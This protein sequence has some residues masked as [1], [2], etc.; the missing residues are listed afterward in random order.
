MTTPA[1]S[2]S[3]SSPLSQ[4]QQQQLGVPGRLLCDNV[5]Y[6]GHVRMAGSA[7]DNK[8][9]ARTAKHI[10]DIH[11]LF[12][13]GRAPRHAPPHAG[14]PLCLIA[15]TDSFS[16]VH[17]RL[18]PSP[19]HAH[20]SGGDE[21]PEQGAGD[22]Q[23]VL[24]VPLAHVVIAHAIRNSVY[25]ALAQPPHA[26]QSHAPPSQQHSQLV[27]HCLEFDLA[28]AA[29]MPMQLQDSI[30]AFQEHGQTRNKEGGKHTTSDNKDKKDRK[31]RKDKE[32]KK[33]KKG[34]DASRRGRSK[35]LRRRS[36][37]ILYPVHR[38]FRRETAT[39]SGTLTPAD[40]APQQPHQR[41]GRRP[42]H[43]V[44]GTQG[45]PATTAATTT[46][47]T[48]TTTDK[49]SRRRSFL[50]GRSWRRRR[51]DGAGH[52]YE[53]NAARGDELARE[54]QRQFEGL[55][56]SPHTRSPATSPHRTAQGHDGYNN[57]STNGSTNTIS[58]TPR[59]WSSG[60]VL[61][62]GATPLSL[63]P[64]PPP[65][66]PPRPLS[67]HH[68]GGRSVRHVGYDDD[69]DDDDDY[70]DEAL[71]EQLDKL[72]LDGLNA[73]G[74]DQPSS[75]P[76]GRR[77]AA[78]SSA[79]VS[80][81]PSALGSPT[82]SPRVLPRPALSLA[83]LMGSSHDANTNDTRSR[84]G[85]I[86]ARG[87]GVN[88]NQS[89][90][91]TAIDTRM[92]DMHSSGGTSATSTATDSNRSSGYR[93][94]QTP[95]PPTM[96]SSN[97]HT[98]QRTASNT[99]ARANTRNHAPTPTFMLAR[100]AKAAG[101]LR[102][103]VVDETLYD[104]EQQPSHGSDGV[105]GE[106]GDDVTF[107][108]GGLVGHSNSTRSGG[109]TH[110]SGSGSGGGGVRVGRSGTLVACDQS[111]VIGGTDAGARSR[112][113]TVTSTA[114]VA[115]GAATSN[116]ARVTVPAGPPPPPLPSRNSTVRGTEEGGYF[117]WTPGMRP[118]SGTYHRVLPRRHSSH[119][120]DSAD[121]DGSRG[122]S[123]GNGGEHGGVRARSAT[124]AN[125]PD[126]FLGAVAAQTAARV[127]AGAPVGT[128]VVRARAGLRASDY[129][130][131]VKSNDGSVQHGD[132]I[133]GPDGLYQ[134]P[135]GAFASPSLASFAFR[136]MRAKKP[137]PGT[138][139]PLMSPLC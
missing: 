61:D 1:S 8:E 86:H 85:N 62:Y 28:T 59:R 21:Q 134:L 120:V 111:A 104:Q 122:D 118:R 137:F 108:F 131:S 112:S 70:D 37:G 139:T 25:I 98:Q 80:S 30:T 64:S 133:K 68:D 127:L 11:L 130:L 138:T 125:M 132:F 18:G 23:L 107:G 117:E 76:S 90:H 40:L 84:N 79:P 114:A 72:D 88:W 128:F 10:Q 95:T 33:D 92:F 53:D 71:Y 43:G 52:H 36:A 87:T 55:A 77:G 41:Q 135:D 103:R 45:T 105:G 34:R 13:S 124:M 63:S 110:G 66:P 67:A 96:P 81:T 12:R 44:Q 119:A 82:S 100:P 27:C 4:Q 50:F 74:S 14:S 73:E 75:Q 123:G 115:G 102:V 58:T 51:S 39:L 136:F 32:D 7:E 9:D 106:G 5:R 93:G 56:L 126:W 89:S 57:S 16:I 42:E 94:A 65:L 6:L 121:G 116:S 29:H 46:A 47:T 31:D 19:S 35:S 2:T 24:H 97:P 113:S 15:G 99:H 22:A 17:P 48:A 91:T 109:S 20:N 38:L 3:P 83:S 60:V 78:S 49:Q 69:D 54:R 26:E 101:P 129:V